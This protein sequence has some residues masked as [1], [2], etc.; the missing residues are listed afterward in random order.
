MLLYAASVHP[1]S[2]LHSSPL[3]HNLVQCISKFIFTFYCLWTHPFHTL[4]PSVL[5]LEMSFGTY[6]YEFLLGIYLGADLW[7]NQFILAP[8]VYDSFICFTFS[9]TLIINVLKFSL[10]VSV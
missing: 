1:F 3:Y 2:L 7:V 5:L 6:M 4:K 10:L 8:T 9:L